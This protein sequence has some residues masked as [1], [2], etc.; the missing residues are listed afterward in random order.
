VSYTKRVE[1]ALRKRPETIA[2]L[3]SYAGE[4]KEIEKEILAQ[5]H[6]SQ[7]KIQPITISHISQLIVCL[8]FLLLVEVLPLGVV[9]S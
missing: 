7:I 4:G 2:D 6:M 5:V 9:Q 8:G 3:A 1:K